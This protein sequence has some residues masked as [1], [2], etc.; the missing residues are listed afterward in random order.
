VV[1]VAL[2][3]GGN[4]LVTLAED[5]G[6]ASGIA[7]VL[8]ATVPLWI[9]AL[10]AIGRTEQLSRRGLAGLAVG[11]AGVVVLVGRGGG[12]SDLVGSLMVLAAALSWSLGSFWSRGAALPRRPIVTT[13]MQMLCGGAAMVVVGLAGGEAGELRLSEV[14]LSAWLGW[15]YLLTFG[16]MLAFTAYAWLLQNAR[17]SLV[18]TYAFVNPAVA[19]ALG[20][21]PP[22]REP[23]SPRTLLAT[24]VI[25]GGVALIV[26]ARRPAP[27]D[28][29]P[30][31]VPRD[32]AREPAR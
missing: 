25:V 12:D 31:T 27:C 3:L 17:L 11:F 19:V 32:P 20:A 10:S 8:I 13:A 16:S 1:G 6:V 9:A 15:L 5:R 23:V 29:P 26:T 24:A 22:L 28:V 2:L 7:A 4:G 30:E 14:G 18:A 21:L